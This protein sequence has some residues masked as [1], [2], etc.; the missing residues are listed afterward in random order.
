MNPVPGWAKILVTV[1][2]CSVIP[3][4]LAVDCNHILH[5]KVGWKVLKQQTTSRGY[6]TTLSSLPVWST[7]PTLRV[8]L[9]LVL[10]MFSS[11]FIS[12]KRFCIWCWW[13]VLWYAVLENEK[14][15]LSL[16]L[17]FPGC[18]LC[19]FPVPPLAFILPYGLLWYG[20]AF[21]LR[22]LQRHWSRFCQGAIVKGPCMSAS[23]VILLLCISCQES[24]RGGQWES[25][26]L[27]RTLLL[28]RKMK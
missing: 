13:L 18:H 22:A 1:A 19:C 14:R 26:G 9:C 27:A 5:M 8:V 15:A 10:G 11:R 3:A 25:R 12:A 17:F 2:L 6:C 7:M 28:Y 24:C 21:L 4:L 16:P 20:L 23:K